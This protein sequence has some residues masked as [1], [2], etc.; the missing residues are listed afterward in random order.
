MKSGSRCTLVIALVL[1]SPLL[2]PGCGGGDSSN[3]EPPVVSSNKPPVTTPEPLRTDALTAVRA[4]AFGYQMPADYG[5]SGT[6]PSIRVV[7]FSSVGNA[8]PQPCPG[9]GTGQ[10]SY[11][12]AD[13]SPDVGDVI[14]VTMADCTAGAAGVDRDSTSGTL[15]TTLVAAT[16]DN[17]MDAAPGLTGGTVRYRQDVRTVFDKVI[18][19][20]A[21]KGDVTTV[22]TCEQVLTHDGHGTDDPADDTRTMMLDCTARSSGTENGAAVALDFTGR[23]SCRQAAGVMTCDSAVVTVRGQAANLGTVAIDATLEPPYTENRQSIPDAHYRVTVGTDVVD[24]RLTNT[25][26]GGRVTVTAPDGST[27]TMTFAE[28]Q[29]IASLY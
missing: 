10:F 1:S 19:G 21:F 7:Y 16:G 9:G 14:T 15:T 6:I 26:P 27:A 5:V 17:G 12:R 11:P 24:I 22:A 4:A 2:L 13:E 25:T 3:P 8:T 18:A 29:S 20:R 23:A 28:F